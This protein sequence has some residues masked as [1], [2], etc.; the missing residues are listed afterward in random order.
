[1]TKKKTKAQEPQCPDYIHSMPKELADL[2]HQ[3]QDDRYSKF[4]AF[5]YLIEKQGIRSLDD[6]DMRLVP[7]SITVTKLSI[8]WN[9]H[10]HTV[11]AF[12]DDLQVLDVL[13]VGKSRDG[14]SIC[15]NKLSFPS[16]A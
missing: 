9:W 11:T 7:F 4:E 12:L 13:T 6:P 8:D 10:R 5:R 15:F 2:L 1:M 14:V 16:V 3:K